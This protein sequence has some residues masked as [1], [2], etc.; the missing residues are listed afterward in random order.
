MLLPGEIIDLEGFR[1]Q[2]TKLEDQCMRLMNSLEEA[3]RTNETLTAERDQYKQFWQATSDFY[4]AMSQ[5][6]VA[7]TTA[8]PQISVPSNAPVLSRDRMSGGS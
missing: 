5:F 4:S 2:A 7:E 8:V 1:S 3:R 6:Q